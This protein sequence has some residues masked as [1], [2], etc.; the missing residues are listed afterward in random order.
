M[1]SERRDLNYSQLPGIQTDIL[2]NFV[3]SIRPRHVHSDGQS[4][5]LQFEAGGFSIPFDQ[6]RFSC[7]YNVEKKLSTGAWGPVEHTK[8][9]AGETVAGA[10]STLAPINNVME[11][12]FIQYDISIND[13]VISESSQMYPWIAHLVKLLNYS[14]EAKST[15]LALSGWSTD[16]TNPDDTTTANTGWVSRMERIKNGRKD[17]VSGVLFSD[18][19]Y[20]LSML[21]S[22]T[23]VR[24]ILQKS[25]PEVFL[26]GGAVGT[27][28]RVNISDVEFHCAKLEISAKK[29]MEIER[30]LASRT[31][32]VV[33]YSHISASNHF[34]ST[35]STKFQV[36]TIIQGQIPNRIIFGLITNKAFTGDT[37]LSPFMYKQHD[38]STVQLC[39]DGRP[40][41]ARPLDMTTCLTAYDNLF[42]NTSQFGLNSTN[43]ITL[44][45]FENGC[46]LYVF[47]CR[48]DRGTRQDLFPQR[49]TGTVSLSL[50][51]GG[52]T[53][54]GLVL[55]CFSEYDQVY[56]IDK[57][58]NFSSDHDMH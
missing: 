18:L 46:L 29:R 5:Q 24:L 42:R 3:E 38:V 25:K 30:Q 56:N 44:N 8:V 45:Q 53:T 1:S 21:P 32:G 22:G 55:I 15:Y 51:F 33:P 39:I 17:F 11:S 35:G 20:A 58:R 12:L 57:L 43:G 37:T 47:N 28:Y 6:C 16:S 49:R 52:T 10:D 2:D 36:P 19:T 34:I 4:I 14:I 48:I 54:E 31:G 23:S 40:L 7:S 50:N 26:Q 13:K 41:E 27:V 9:L